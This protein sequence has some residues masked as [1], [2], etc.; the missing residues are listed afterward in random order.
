[1][2][3]AEELRREYNEL[4]A[5][6]DKGRLAL[7]Q[8]LELQEEIGLEG[9][10]YAIFTLKEAECNHFIAEAEEGLATL[11]HEIERLEAYERDN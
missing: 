11:K 10:M 2:S 6:L 9:E 4:R 1:M 3:I 7:G 5:K 8:L